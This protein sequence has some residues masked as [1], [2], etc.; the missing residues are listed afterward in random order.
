MIG[1][2]QPRFPLTNL[3]PTFLALAGTLSATG[4][5]VMITNLKELYFHQIEDLYS[6]ES[7]IL[8]AM[9]NM[10]A[11]AQD[12]DLKEALS[13]HQQETQTQKKRLESIFAN[14]SLAAEKDKCF[15]AEGI[16]K[17]ATHLLDEL[18]GKVVDAGI[19]AAAQR[20]EHY[21][22]AAMARPRRSAKHLGYGDDVDLLDETLDEESDANEK[23]TG[24]AESHLFGLVDGL[25]E[26]AD[27]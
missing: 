26:K 10:I 9:P 25:N 18:Q 1:P 14:H 27:V 8:T 5:P 22:I 19:I 20:F 21:E 17:E 15:A 2:I 11:K 16:I 6:A 4:V 7:Q 23:L 24:L 12:P 3:I 13:A